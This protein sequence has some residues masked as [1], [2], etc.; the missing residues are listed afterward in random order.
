MAKG[1][2]A[3]V[4]NCIRRQDGPP[5]APPA[6]GGRAKHPPIRIKLSISHPNSFARKGS[7]TPALPPETPVSAQPTRRVQT[8]LE[9][10]A[11]VADPLGAK[12]LV[13][14]LGLI[15]MRES[16]L[17]PHGYQAK[18]SPHAATRQGG[19]EGGIFSE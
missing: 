19:I 4:L 16:Q 9:H 6:C 7:A 13:P 12:S 17:S 10:K 11:R 14:V 2:Q 15:R 1:V 3:V 5:P 18:N 8:G